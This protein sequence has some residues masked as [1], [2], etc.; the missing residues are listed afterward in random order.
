MPQEDCG[1]DL[2]FSN[3]EVVSFSTQVGTQGSIESL[4]DPPIPEDVGPST[5]SRPRKVTSNSS[6]SEWKK[7]ASTRYFQYSPKLGTSLLLLRMPALKITQK[8][9]VYLRN[10]YV[11]PVR[12][13]RHHAPRYQHS[14]WSHPNVVSILS[15]K[16]RV[17]FELMGP[18][19]P[20]IQDSM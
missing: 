8:T 10:R 16:S 19:V 17:F 20:S 6:C 15:C 5:L 4:W 7:D 18:C 12:I 9:E 2:G 3:R 11:G 13:L 1:E 14:P